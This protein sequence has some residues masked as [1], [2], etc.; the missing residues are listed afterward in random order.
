MNIAANIR[1]ADLEQH[2]SAAI[3]KPGS[4]RHTLTIGVLPIPV[5]R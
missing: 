2:K 1:Q 5:Q 4:F 3:G